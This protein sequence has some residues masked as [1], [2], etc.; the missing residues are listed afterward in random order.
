MAPS[1]DSRYCPFLVDDVD[2]LQNFLS[3]KG[4]NSSEKIKKLSLSI[5]VGPNDAD[6]YLDLELSNIPLMHVLAFMNCID[7]I[8]YLHRE[9]HVD[10][11][12][13]T[14]NS[15]STLHYAIHGHAELVIAY[16]LRFAPHDKIIRIIKDE[17]QRQFK[18][19][20]LGISSNCSYGLQRLLEFD[21]VHNAELSTFMNEIDWATKR[22]SYECLEFIFN[23]FV[24]KFNG[25]SPLRN[26]IARQYPKLVKILLRSNPTSARPQDIVNG[27]TILDLACGSKGTDPDATIDIINTVLDYYNVRQDET[28]IF[29]ALQSGNLQIVN[30]V[31][32]MGCKISN[33]LK[34]GRNPAGKLC[35]LDED[36]AIQI[37][38]VMIDKGLDINYTGPSRNTAFGDLLT[39]LKKPFHLLDYMLEIGA[40]MTKPYYRN[41]SATESNESIA[42]FVKNNK[43]KEFQALVRNHPKSFERIK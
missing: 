6:L 31:I 21:Y 32:K 29:A 11:L 37:L 1:D 17:K 20:Y 13:L 8:T 35:F 40:D 26:A 14:S 19:V 18:L 27:Q 30:R 5:N 28:A 34:D 22:N 33:V 3:Q 25:D 15:Y 23:Y 36:E 9:Y 43:S 7:C 2:L 38:K 42:A 4:A 16:I 24:V 39:C 10:L 12:Q 41:L